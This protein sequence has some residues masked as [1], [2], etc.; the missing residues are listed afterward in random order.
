[1][2]NTKIT[3]GKILCCELIFLPVRIDTVHSYA[4][5]TL[6]H[7]FEQYWGAGLF[8]SF[9]FAHLREQVTA[10]SLYH[11]TIFAKIVSIHV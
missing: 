3:C 6:I 5:F 4:Q 7:N 9:K 2:L 8:K 1:M 10:G 11:K